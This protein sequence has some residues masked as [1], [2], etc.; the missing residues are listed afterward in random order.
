MGGSRGWEVEIHSEPVA[1]VGD[2]PARNANGNRG[3][4][5]PPQGK[6]DIG[7]QAESGE[8]DPEDF[9]FHPI[10]LFRRLS[11]SG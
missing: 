9:A 2:P 7:E 1:A 3:E 10:I 11:F 5:R 6:H 8:G 4:Q